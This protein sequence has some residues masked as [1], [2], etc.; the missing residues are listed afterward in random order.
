MFPSN[1]GNPFRMALPGGKSV[2]ISFPVYQP[3]TSRDTHTCTLTHT[4]LVIILRNWPVWSEIC[5][6]DQ[7]AGTLGE[8]SV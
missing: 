5:R 3:E 6:A 2:Q 1:H 4:H 8:V 7:Y